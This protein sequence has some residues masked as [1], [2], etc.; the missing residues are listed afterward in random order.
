MVVTSH[1]LKPAG[2]AR[3]SPRSRRDRQAEPPGSTEDGCPQI[4]IKPYLR[5]KTLCRCGKW[6]LT[7]HS[8]MNEHELLGVG[9]SKGRR[10]QRGEQRGEQ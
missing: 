4:L 1:A 8:Q 2:G 6:A 10:R 7:K 3:A 9:N 5:G